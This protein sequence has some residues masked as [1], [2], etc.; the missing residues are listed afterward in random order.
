M[1]R[2]ERGWLVRRK[3]CCEKRVLEEFQEWVIREI[4]PLELGR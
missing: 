2:K 1:S 3:I 4:L